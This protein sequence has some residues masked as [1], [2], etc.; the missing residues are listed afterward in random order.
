[1]YIQVIKTP[2]INM[3]V[4]YNFVSFLFF[5]ELQLDFVVQM[6]QDYMQLLYLYISS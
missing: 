2:E 6:G 4:V 1:M 3:V 5:F